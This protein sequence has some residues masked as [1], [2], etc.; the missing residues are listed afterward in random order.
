MHTPQSARDNTRMNFLALEDFVNLGD[1]PRD[2]VKFRQKYPGF[3]P[4]RLVKGE[5]A[6]ETKVSPFD[7]RFLPAILAWRDLLREVWRGDAAGWELETLLGIIPEARERWAGTAPFVALWN[8]GLDAIEGAG[9]HIPKELARI[10]AVWQ[11]GQFDYRGT[12]FEDAVFALWKSHWR[13]KVCPMCESYFIARPHRKAQR[14]CSA[15]CASEGKRESN[16]R[17]WRESGGDWRRRLMKEKRREEG[18][19]KTKGRNGP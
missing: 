17:W 16:R 15:F 2:L 1:S 6:D 14:F 9:L 3:A 5:G 7:A 18:R 8:H 4:F 12:D 19:R 10:T 11:D 13:A